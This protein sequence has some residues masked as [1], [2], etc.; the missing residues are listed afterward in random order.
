MKLKNETL[1]NE[2]QKEIQAIQERYNKLEIENQ[3]LGSENQEYKDGWELDQGIIQSHER[4]KQKYKIELQEKQKELEASE[5]RSNKLQTEKQRLEEEKQKYKN[6]LQ[7][8]QNELQAQY[9]QYNTFI[10]RE[11]LVY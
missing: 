3:K 11:F 1:N 8:K 4:E 7:E 5:E 10:K 6:E 9:K 2:K